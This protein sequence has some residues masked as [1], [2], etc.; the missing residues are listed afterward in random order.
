MIMSFGDKEK[1]YMKEN[2]FDFLKVFHKIEC[3]SYT[4]DVAVNGLIGNS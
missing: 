1:L 4:N 3:H 2:V